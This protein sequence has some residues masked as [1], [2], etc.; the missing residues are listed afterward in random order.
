MGT[1]V[2]A[3]RC[4]RD[5]EYSCRRYCLTL[6]LHKTLVA[7]LTEE[8]DRHRAKFWPERT[9]NDTN[10]ENFVK[11]DANYSGKIIIS[12]IQTS[13]VRTPEWTGGNFAHL[14]MVSFL[15]RFS[16][17]P[18]Q[19]SVSRWLTNIKPQTLLSHLDR[20]PTSPSTSIFVRAWTT[21]Q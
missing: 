6:H 1:Y 9:R 17:S 20:S 13:R 19:L 5:S 21:D 15:F 3:H 10:V 4:D 11:A 12:H 16:L 18:E 7:K 8:Y 2:E 14:R